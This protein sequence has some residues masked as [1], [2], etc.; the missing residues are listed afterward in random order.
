MSKGAYGR[1]VGSVFRGT[2]DFASEPFDWGKDYQRP[3]LAYED[4]IVYEVPVRTFT[5]S[6]TS[7]V[8]PEKA[9]S[10]LGFAEKVFMYFVL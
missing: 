1:Q 3:N 4:L 8:D 6:P 10:F 2:Y 9:G 7:N 5:A